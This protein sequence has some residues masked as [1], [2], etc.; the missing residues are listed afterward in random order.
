[1]TRYRKYPIWRVL[2]VGIIP[3]II[4]FAYCIQGCKYYITNAASSAAKHRGVNNVFVAILG[5]IA[6]NFVKVT[7]K[8]YRNPPDPDPNNNFG[9]AYEA[10][11]KAEGQHKRDEQ[12]VQSKRR[13]E[14]H[15]R[16]LTRI[17]QER[18][19]EIA[20]LEK[21]LNRYKAFPSQES[22]EQD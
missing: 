11:S 5:V 12:A 4:C 3:S 18:V 13:A 2:L 17:K 19:N 6:L 16:D 20:A 1:M 10:K 8:E 7:H 21:E 14:E 22:D 15:E 9:T